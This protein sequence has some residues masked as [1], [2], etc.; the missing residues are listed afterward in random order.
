MKKIIYLI[1]A[2]AILAANSLLAHIDNYLLP[3]ECGSCHVGHGLQ[4]EPM[5]TH[6]EEEA[7]Y[8]CHG[9][10]NNR[11]QMKSAGKLSQQ[12]EL[13]NIESEFNKI[14]RHPVKSGVGHSSSEKL[15]GLS[16][17]SINHSECVD[18][19]NPHQRVATGEKTYDVAGMSLSGQYVDKS[20]KEYEV[21]LKCHGTNIGIKS[22]LI[23]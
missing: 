14:Y 19:H 15:P 8:Q 2:I 20:I 3:E 7:C 23:W 1:F 16:S 22:T 11:T 4:G 17:S 13:A 9:S 12:A 10:D 18:C 5:L 6:S 21:C